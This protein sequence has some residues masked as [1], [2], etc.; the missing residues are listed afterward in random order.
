[1]EALFLAGFNGGL[2]NFALGNVLD[3]FRVE[4]VGLAGDSGRI[5]GDMTTGKIT[6]VTSMHFCLYPA[7]AE[8]WTTLKPSVCL[9]LS[10]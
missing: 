4:S 10:C 6:G 2:K 1:M 5:A 9:Q 3:G 8:V 7:P